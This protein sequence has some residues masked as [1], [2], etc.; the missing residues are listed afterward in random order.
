MHH[1]TSGNVQTKH[2]EE[3]LMFDPNHFSLSNPDLF[4]DPYPV[5]E[6]LRERDPIHKS[7]MYGGSWVLFS[8]EHAAA[9]LRDPWLTN[10]RATLPIMALPEEQRG[11]FTDFVAFLRTW[12]AFF[13]GE[14]HL[15]RRRHM[16][17]VF[18]VLTPARITQVVQEAVDR[19]ID[20]WG[21]RTRVDLVTE[22]ARPLPAMVFTRLMGAPES[23]H[24]QLDHWA[25]DIAYLFG[26]SKLSVE[27][28]RRAWASAQ[29]LMAYLKELAADMAR[30]PQNSLLGALMTQESS[31]FSF[32]EAEACAQC[33]L[34]MF[35][36]LEPSRHL[37]GNA[38]LALHRFPDQRRLLAENPR[39]W[40]A[41]VEEFQR[42]DAPVQYIGRMAAESFT[43][44]G[45]NIEKGQVVLPYVGS[46]NRDPKQFADPDVLDVRRRGKHLAM[47]EGVHRCIGAGLVRIQT[48]VA[49]RTLLDRVPQLD[50][51]TDTKP[52]WNS[53]V[54][55]H[56]LES[57]TVS[58]KPTADLERS[59][60]PRL[61][62]AC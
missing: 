46:A 24:A 35:A 53:Y 44:R 9:L 23:D 7:R 42:F 57:L 36:G 15:L 51:C 59:G 30:L 37:I 27:D 17:A 60:L 32:T 6:Q 52:V 11:E 47:G 38:I 55:F 26:A 5:Y 19:L 50:V 22:F 16:N 61:A 13:E 28:V 40:P 18:R 43:Y 3:N 34:L 49:L 48:G 56:G 29:S 31:G 62:I 4:I 1:S 41:A 14:D 39:L 20:G 10:N 8:Y 54:G 33:V 25:D 21:G 2:S 12:S 45:H 58:T